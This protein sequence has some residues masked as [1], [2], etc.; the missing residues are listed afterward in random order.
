MVEAN[1]VAAGKLAFARK[2]AKLSVEIILATASAVDWSLT[3]MMQ[4]RVVGEAC[5]RRRALPEDITC[6]TMSLACT[7]VNELMAAMN[8]SCLTAS[9]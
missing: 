9:N 3:W 8:A 4:A 5:S 6:T 7:P 1:M 2:G